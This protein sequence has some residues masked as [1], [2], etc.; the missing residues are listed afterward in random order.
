MKK[1]MH[2]G[3]GNGSNEPPAHQLP[4]PSVVVKR[5]NNQL[6]LKNFTSE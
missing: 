1:S 4:P 2:V 5:N 6:H 3:I